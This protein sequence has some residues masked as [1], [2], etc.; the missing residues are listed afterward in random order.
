LRIRK[1][2]QNPSRFPPNK[3]DE[4]HR[5]AAFLKR[6]GGQEDKIQILSM[7]KTKKHRLLKLFLREA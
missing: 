7:V 3:F 6:R 4:Y 1:L 2:P 5:L